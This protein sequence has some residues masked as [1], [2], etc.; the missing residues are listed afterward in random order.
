[1][2]QDELKELFLDYLQQ[3]IVVKQPDNLYKP[4]DYILQLGGKRLRPLLSLIAAQAFGKK[5]EKALDVA[6]AIEVFHNFTL[7][8]DDIMDQAPIRRGQLTVHKKWNLNTGILSG[9]VML[10]NAYQFLENYDAPVYKQLTQVFSKTAVEVCEGQQYDMDFETRNNVT[11]L[12]YLM[13]IK[14]K[15]SILLAAALQMGAIVAGASQSDQLKI[16]N[17]GIDL[18]LAFQLQD[19]YLDTFGNAATFGKQIGGDILENK[20]TWLYLK[21][22]EVASTEDSRV[23]LDMYQSNIKNDSDKIKMITKLFEQY[24][25]DVLLQKEISNY[26]QKALVV[27]ERLDIEVTSKKLLKELVFS[28]EKRSQ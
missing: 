25:I 3:K 26:T 21:T 7:L 8:H 24:Q 2:N 27:L 22:L 18:G 12:E 20:K 19:D 4:V 23:L 13:M 6:L 17:F 5:P 28:L 11:I 1:M 10:I 16:Y 14:Y 15:T 9:D